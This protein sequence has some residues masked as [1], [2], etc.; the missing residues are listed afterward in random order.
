MAS[1]RVSVQDGNIT[2]HAVATIEKMA[3]GGFGADVASGKR[4]FFLAVGFHK[5]HVR[6]VRVQQLN[7]S[8]ACTLA[9]YVLVG[10]PDSSARSPLQPCNLRNICK[11][12]RCR[13][14]W[15]TDMNCLN[16]ILH[17]RSCRCHGGRQR[18]SGT[19]TRLRKFPPCRT[20]AWSPPTLQWRCKTGRRV[21]ASL[22]TSRL[23]RS[24]LSL[25]VRCASRPDWRD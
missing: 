25:S 7:C 18:G 10:V 12:Q 17:L 19:C 9:Y 13:R 5:P 8:V 11:K 2:D 20:R 1:Y 23:Q 6:P 21:S 4:P 15:K 3:S 22:L 14:Y 24:I 16:A